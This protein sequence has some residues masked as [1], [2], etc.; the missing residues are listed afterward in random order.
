MYDANAGSGGGANNG[1]ATYHAAGFVTGF[2]KQRV[3][4]LAGGEQGGETMS[5]TEGGPVKVGSSGADNYLLRVLRLPV[6]MPSLE[7]KC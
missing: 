4:V 2:E 6:T 7:V 3:V 5:T 1:N